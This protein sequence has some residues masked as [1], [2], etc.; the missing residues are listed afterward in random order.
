MNLQPAVV[1]NESQF[2]EPVHEEAAPRT[3]CADH[4]RQ[5]L[6]ADLWNYVLGHA[7]FAKTGEQQKDPGQP[8][9][10]RIEKLV[11]QSFFVT[12]VP[13]QQIGYEHVGKSV[14]P[15]KRFHHGSLLD[16][17]NSAIRHCGCGTHAEQLA[18][19]RT[20]AEKVS[21]TQY[22][23]RCFLACLRDHGES[24][25][26]RLYIKHRIGGIPLRKDS[27]FLPEEHAFPALAN[28]CDECME[29]EMT[30]LLSRCNGSHGWV[31][32]AR[33]SGAIACGTGRFLSV[34][35]T[36]TS[37]AQIIRVNS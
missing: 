8:L 25:L 22:S 20:F 19:K 36:H 34:S 27:L 3:G 6:L 1:V 37:V 15:V 29:I 12:D 2:P 5:H 21:L 26:A 10:A 13:R 24:Y 14:F 9:F 17:Q 28:G 7:F 31:A 16:S 32:Q 35:A 18:P 4:S 33:E 23:D 11:N 30:L